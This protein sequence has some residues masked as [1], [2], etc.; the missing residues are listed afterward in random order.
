[1]CTSPLRAWQRGAAAPVFR[2]PTLDGYRVLELPC[3]QCFECRLDYS[4]QWAV[5]CVHE[6]KMHAESCM[7]TLTYGAE[8]LPSDL[9]LRPSDFTLFMKRL[10]ERLRPQLVRFYMC[11]EYGDKG[12]RPHYHCLLFGYSPVDK[13]FWKTSEAGFKCYT[14]KFMES[15]WQ[16]GSVFVGDVTFESAAYV[17]RYVMKKVGSDGKYREILDV[18]T[19]EIILREHEY[20]QMSLKPG[21]GGA[22]FAQYF[23]DVFP[24]DRV[25]VRGVK[26]KVPRYYNE[27]LKRFNPVYL[28]ELQA[29]RVLKVNFEETFPKRLRARDVVLRARTSSLKRG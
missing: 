8:H 4:R 22:W 27:L 18:E 15:V 10:R 14:S 20:S 6:A 16:N 9:S 24:H 5:R 21:I 11:G 23:S 17:A 25:V 2:V 1:M 3:G 26:H 19:G 12:S 13:V 7:L 28:A 29:K